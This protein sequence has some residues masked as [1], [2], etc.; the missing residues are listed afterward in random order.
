MTGSIAWIVAEG[1]GTTIQSKNNTIRVF[2]DTPDVI[3]R[4]I[5][6]NDGAAV[7]TD[8][9]DFAATVNATS[10]HMENPSES[11]RQGMHVHLLVMASILYRL[12]RQT[13][14]HSLA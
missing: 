2:S 4:G 12:R 3:V 14:K 13:S 5:M 10:A 8:K 9:D 11:Q 7:T 6:A 1:S